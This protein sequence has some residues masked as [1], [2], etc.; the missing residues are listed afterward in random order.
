MKFVETR[1]Q[2]DP[3]LVNSFFNQI[4]LGAKS[5]HD[6]KLLHLYINPR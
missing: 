1:G 4:I 3:N 6:N 2:L 5:L